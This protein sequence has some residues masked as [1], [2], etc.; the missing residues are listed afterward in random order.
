MWS[1]HTIEYYLAI[2]TDPCYNMD[3]SK[4]NMMLSGRNQ[5]QNTTYYM[6]PLYEISKI[7]KSTEKENMLVV[8]EDLQEGTS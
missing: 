5:S 3:A 6:I 2:N 8:A 4:K 1:I 7:G